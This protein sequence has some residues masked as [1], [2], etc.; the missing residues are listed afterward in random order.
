LR[1]V[2]THHLESDPTTGRRRILRGVAKGRQLSLGDPAMGHR[3]KAAVAPFTGYKRHVVKLLEADLIVEA[4][5]RPANESEYATLGMLATAV[6]AA[7]ASQRVVDG[8]GSAT[9]GWAE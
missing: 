1:V 3:R 4:V 5:A 8:G 7:I 6:A 9:R 2:L